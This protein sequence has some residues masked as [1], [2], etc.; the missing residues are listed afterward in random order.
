MTLTQFPAAD[1]ALRYPD[2]YLSAGVL[3]GYF[4]PSDSQL[5]DPSRLVSPFNGSIRPPEN[6][7]GPGLSE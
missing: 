3:G 4:K 7:G 5:A 6:A 1:M 2:R